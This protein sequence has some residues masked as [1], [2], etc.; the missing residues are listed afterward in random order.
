VK[1]AI[2]IVAATVQKII[3][4][5]EVIQPQ[6][7]LR[8]PCYDGMRKGVRGVQER[9]VQYVVWLALLFCAML[10]SLAYIYA[11]GMKYENADDQRKSNQ[12]PKGD[13]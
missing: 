2:A 3:L 10:C 13:R 4:R 7:P 5:K 11:D 12:K 6:V 8:L 9:D 1:Q